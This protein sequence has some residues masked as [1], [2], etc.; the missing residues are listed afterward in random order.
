MTA[1]L[2]EVGQEPTP[3]VWSNERYLALVE[4]GVIEEGRGVELVD[5]QIIT[6]MPQGEL[7][8][9]LF[10]A[11]QAA[12]ESMHAASRGLRTQPTVQIAEGQTYDPEFAL[13]RPEALRLRRLPRGDEVLW[14]VEVSVSSRRID[15]GPKKAAYARAGIPDYWVVD[16]VE[17]GVH[18]FSDPRD[19]AYQNELFVPAGEMLIV[20]ALGATLDSADV[21]PLA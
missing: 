10:F 5:G 12:F 21:F 19:G 8:Q 15:L 13:L 3:F 18:A 2:S 16:A 11:L 9:F 17:R 7:H 6:T 1:M 14:V 20:P 4:S